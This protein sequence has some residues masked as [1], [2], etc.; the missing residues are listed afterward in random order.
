MV[1]IAALCILALAIGILNKI[2]Y[3]GFF[4]FPWSYNNPYK[5]VL[6]EIDVV[7]V[8][9]KKLGEELESDNITYDE[10]TER[11]GAI[12]VEMDRLSKVEIP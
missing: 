1:L 11:I 9:L 3:G 7:R 12:H 2:L 4:I 5:I 10:Y 6:R 8:A